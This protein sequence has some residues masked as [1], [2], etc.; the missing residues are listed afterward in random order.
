M[1]GIIGLICPSGLTAVHLEKFT[2][3]LKRCQTRGHHATGIFTS[4]MKMLKA[5]LP[6]SVFITADK[7]KEFITAQ[8]AN[9][10]TYIVGHTR[11]ATRGDPKINTNNH[12]F[13]GTDNKFMLV[14]NGGVT[15]TKYD[16]NKDVT[17]TYIYVEAINSFLT[18]HSVPEAVKL[19]FEDVERLSSSS[20][21][22]IVVGGEGKVM[23][24]KS[25]TYPMVIQSINE[26]GVI[27]FAST[28]DIM[29]P[30]VNAVVDGVKKKRWEEVNDEV[31][32]VIDVA[33]RD[34]SRNF[35]A[36]KRLPSQTSWREAI[37]V[38]D[39]DIGDF[40][41]DSTGKWVRKP[42]TLTATGSTKLEDF[43]D[44]EPAGTK[45]KLTKKEK[46]A[47][48]KARY[49]GEKK[50]VA[51][52]TQPSMT[53]K[54]SVLKNWDSYRASFDDEDIAGREIDGR[55]VDCFDCQNAKELEGYDEELLL[56]IHDGTVDCAEFGYEMNSNEAQRCPFF[57]PKGEE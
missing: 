55:K 31:V 10:M 15:C 18:G 23:F 28:T 24:C 46:R 14:H 30:E 37:D 25:R 32:V 42:V 51:L 56:R 13:T 53:Q 29:E 12:P 26:T 7:Y 8:L 1:C 9:G 57:E 49:E 35:L 17:D 54:K 3:M 38:P 21:G 52:A 2:A 44:T 19:G 34:I 22:V 5:P 27:L 47:R 39:I 43:T 41:K 33:T 48:R 20:N 45:R 50:A 4:N 36:T 6:S 16:K 11:F 40:D